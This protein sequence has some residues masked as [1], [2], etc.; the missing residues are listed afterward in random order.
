M[1]LRLCKNAVH[2]F[3]IDIGEAEVA[4]GVAVREADVGVEEVV[5]CGG[6][7]GGRGVVVRFR[8]RETI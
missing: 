8:L 7:E 4:A 2:H 6:V 3:A 1:L 5:G